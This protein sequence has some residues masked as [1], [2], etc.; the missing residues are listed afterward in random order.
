MIFTFEQDNGEQFEL[1]IPIVTL[2]ASGHLKIVSIWD[3]ATLPFGE[4]IYEESGRV[5]FT[6]LIDTDNR[7][8]YFQYNECNDSSTLGEDS[9]YPDLADFMDEMISDMKVPENDW[10]CFVMDLRN[11][12]GGSEFLWNGALLKY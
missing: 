6:Y 4:K 1:A 12:R 3:N 8:V 2:V 10:E 5:P 11:N 9:G 7:A